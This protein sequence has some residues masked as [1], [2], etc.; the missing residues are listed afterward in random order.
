MGT[1]VAGVVLWYLYRWL[2]LKRV[3]DEQINDPGR[4]LSWWKQIKAFLVA[5]LS[6]L[7]SAHAKRTALQFYAALVRWGR[8]SG[9]KQEPS[10]TPMEYGRRLSHQFPQLKTE[11]VLIIDMLHREVYGQTDLDTRQINGIRQSWKKL[12]SPAKWPMRI[13]SMITKNP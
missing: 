2:F 7:F 6:W 10:E 8:H 9:F 12:H 1:A 11:I 4:L 13:K 5:C 3:G